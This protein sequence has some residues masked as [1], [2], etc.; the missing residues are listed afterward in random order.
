MS[1]NRPVQTI[2]IKYIQNIGLVERYSVLMN[3]QDGMPPNKRSEK[4]DDNNTNLT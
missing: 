3:F 4:H 1:L 2:F